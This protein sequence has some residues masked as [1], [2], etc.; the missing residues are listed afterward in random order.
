MS[1]KVPQ[2]LCICPTR[3]LVLQN[4]SVLTRLGKFSGIKA[5]ATGAWRG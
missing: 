5:S 4:L 1:R 2:A 3:E